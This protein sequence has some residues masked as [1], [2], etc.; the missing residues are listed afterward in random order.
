MAISLRTMS[1][2]PDDVTHLVIDQ[3]ADRGTLISRKSQVQHATPSLLS[4]VPACPLQAGN[5]GSRMLPYK[6]P[7]IH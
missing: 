3:N 7:L 4:G 1:A 2:A 6:Y 5:S